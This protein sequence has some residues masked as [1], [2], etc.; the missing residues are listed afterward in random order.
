MNKTNF[1]QYNTAWAKLGYPKKPWYI[2]DCGCGEVAIANCII[3]MEK[4]ANET[5]KTIQPYCKQFAASNGD[6]TFWSAPPI[7]MAHYGMTEV[8]EHQTMAPLWKELAK[9]GRV[10]IYLMSN[11]KAGSKGIKWTGSKHF[12]CSVDYRYNEK[13]G[14]H[15]VYVKD[16]NTTSATRNG[17]ITYEDF[18]KNAVFKVWSG[19]LNGRLYGEAYYPTT[20]YTGTLPSGT[21]KKGGKG[22][23]VKAVQRFLNWCMNSKLAVDGDCGKNTDNAIRKY[24]TQYKLKVDGIFGSAS[25]KKAQEIVD[26]YAPK[27]TL[28]EK[29]LAACAEQAERMK[30]SKYGWR[31]NPTVEN[32]EEEGTCVTFVSCVLQIIGYLLSGKYIWHDKKGKVIGATDRMEVIYPNNKKLRELKNELK[33]G[34]IIMDGSKS[35]VGSGSH[36][37]IFTGKWDGDKPIIWDNHS[38]QQNKGAYAYDRNRNV[39]AIVRLKQV[40]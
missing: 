32:S 40:R 28:L 31:K 10:A 14:K 2:K 21:V 39:I 35:D 17:W 36:I 33:A 29:E 20:P 24:Q 25:K 30:N 3:E 34:D 8:Q 11:R 19:K 27:D 7:M 23:D 6:G 15:E 38:G 13:T 26:K 16:S 1:K 22:N 9:G 18:M 12:I 5:P 37:F 4:Y